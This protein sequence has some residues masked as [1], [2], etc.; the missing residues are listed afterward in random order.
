MSMP[1]LS[2]SLPRSCR[3]RYQGISF[4]FDY[5]VFPG[6]VLHMFLRNPVRCNCSAKLTI[7]ERHVAGF[8][9]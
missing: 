9:R 5:F 4:G 1:R 6:R 2:Q 7:R 8:L 3:P